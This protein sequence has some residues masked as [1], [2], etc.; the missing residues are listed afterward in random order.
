MILSK[1]AFPKSWEAVPLVLSDQITVEAVLE[2]DQATPEALQSVVSQWELRD[3]FSGFAA[4][5]AGAVATPEGS[6]FFGAV[7]DGR[8]V[9]FCPMQHDRTGFHGRVLRYDTQSDFHRDASYEVYDASRTDGLDTRGYYGGAFDGRHVYFVPRKTESGR[10]SRVLRFDTSGDFH[11]PASW[12]AHDPGLTNC[13]QGAAFDGRYLYMAPGYDDEDPGRETISSNL[14]LRFDT[15]GGF[16]D[17]ASWTT[18]DAASGEGPCGCFDGAVFDG[19]FVYFVPLLHEVVLRYD[20]RAPFDA[21]GSWQRFDGSGLK[22]GSNVGAVFD[23]TAVYFVPYGHSR[24]VRYDCRGEFS[25]P[26]NWSQVDLSAIFPQRDLGF[27]GGFYDG[28][29]VYYVPFVADTG[30]GLS[31]HANFV[32]YDRTMSFADPAAW[33]LHDAA[34]TSGLA[35]RGYNAGAFDGRYFYCAP[36]RTGTGA[37]ELGIGVHARIL[38]Y[39][40]TGNRAVFSLRL[41]DFGHNGGLCASVP[42]PTFLVNT[43]RGVIGVSS[44]EVLAPGRHHLAGVYDGR[45]IRLYLNGRLVAERAASGKIVN[46]DL[47]I[48]IGNGPSE[49]GRSS[50]RIL[51]VRVKAEASGADALAARAQQADCPAV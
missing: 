30:N 47:P 32:R 21:A 13:R 11:S 40:T 5:D 45:F 35:T 2:F 48:Q 18:Y 24:A 1:A 34:S 7:F 37:G 9:Y 23:G 41:N 12:S 27:D 44:H 26:A 20:T 39:D 19:R 14:V 46:A 25:D 29:Y 16:R 15:Q 6:G 49:S 3:A 4:H 51:S 28:R 10:H 50:A 22:L 36:W 42:G 33:C 38:R 31:F 8:H 43:D 17:K